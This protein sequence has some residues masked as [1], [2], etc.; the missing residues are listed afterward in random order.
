M[1]Y[2]DCDPL[3]TYDT[4]DAEDGITIQTH[5]ETELHELEATQYGEL[6]SPGA[7]E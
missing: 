1:R 2:F 3:T 6:L 5:E 7:M 4:Y